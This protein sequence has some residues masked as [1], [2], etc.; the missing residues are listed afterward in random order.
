VSVSVNVSSSE[1]RAPGFVERVRA[2]LRETG[3]P[4]EA[5]I[6]EITERVLARD[7]DEVATRMRDLSA[8][9]VR[10][11]IDDFGTGFSSLLYLKRLPVTALKVAQEFVRDM[12]HDPVDA[13]IV[14]ATI[15]LAGALGLAII[16]EGVETRAQ[17]RELAALGC[18]LAQGYRYGRPVPASAIDHL[19]ETTDP[20]G[21]SGSLPRVR[22]TRPLDPSDA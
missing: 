8:D 22:L 16:A 5:L 12:L 14:R 21:S 15:S 7:L 18:A 20:L 9:G 10:F 17:E 2:T 1:F 11:A 6:L 4:G 19:L 3:L 13:E